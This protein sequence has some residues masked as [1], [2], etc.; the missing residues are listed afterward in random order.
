MTAEL[1]CG[2]FEAGLPGYVD[3][4]SPPTERAAMDAHRGECSACAALFA[5]YVA[6]PGIVRSATHA[7]MPSDARAQLRRL[8]AH[9]W[10]RRD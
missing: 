6:L 5:D 2:A 8:L 1:S 4:R 7:E 3:N 10:R 9:T